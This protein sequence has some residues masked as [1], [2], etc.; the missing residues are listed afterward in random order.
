MRA[1]SLC[2][3]RGFLIQLTRTIRCCS[4]NFPTSTGLKRAVSPRGAKAGVGE[5]EPIVYFARVSGKQFEVGSE[6]N[7][8]RRAVELKTKEQRLAL[9][10]KFLDTDIEISIHDLLLLGTPSP[11]L[12]CL[13]LSPHCKPVYLHPQSLPLPLP[14]AIPLHVLVGADNCSTLIWS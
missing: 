9:R 12:E 7:V 2:H 3:I 4:F 11:N 5:E 6:R 8:S 13:L 10:I 1:G 14:A